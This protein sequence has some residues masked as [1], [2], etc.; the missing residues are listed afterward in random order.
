MCGGAFP[1]DR[2]GTITLPKLPERH[3]ITEYFA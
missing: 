3:Y 2:A 1:L